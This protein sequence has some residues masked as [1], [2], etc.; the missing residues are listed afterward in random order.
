MA[1]IGGGEAVLLEIG[2]LERQKCKQMIKKA[3]NL[4]GSSSSP[5]PDTGGDKMHERNALPG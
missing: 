4:F 3:C 2:R 5:R 1:N